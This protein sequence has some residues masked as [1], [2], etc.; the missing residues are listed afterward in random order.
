MANNS[1][2]RLKI[3]RFDPDQDAE[4]RYDTFE[5]PTP[6][7]LTVLEA[8]F[9]ILETVDPS[10]AFRYSC[11]GAVCG[12]CAVYINGRYELACGTQVSDFKG[13][14]IVISPLPHLE[15]IRDLVVDME[16]FFAKYEAIKP[17]LVNGDAPPEKERLQSPEEYKRIE[18]MIDCI[19]CASCYS[20]CPS[21]WTDPRYS[22]PSAIMKANRFNVDSRDQGTGERMPV[23][24]H[25]DGLW[26][27]H[28]IFN[29]V[30]ACPKDV[31]P[32]SAI[33]TAKRAAAKR[34]FGLK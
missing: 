15:V 20:S 4:P 3:F 16:P 32:T 25:E 6:E 10:I 7:G 24:D 21:V 28:T 8:L 14:E 17:Y 30:E 22:G 23:L 29:C 27:C 11:R 31:N 19:L 5:I 13:K 18:E 26:R 12:S 1:T 33:Q 34:K 2:A 9:Y